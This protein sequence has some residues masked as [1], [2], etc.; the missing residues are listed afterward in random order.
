MSDLQNEICSRCEAV[1]DT[2]GTPHWCK[3]CRAKYMREYQDLKKQMAA[4]KGFV[5]GAETMR[6]SLLEKLVAMPPIGLTNFAEMARWIRE[7]PTPR[8][9]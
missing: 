5:A 2:E 4:G 9:Q 7:F 1:L 8:P 6:N 3:A